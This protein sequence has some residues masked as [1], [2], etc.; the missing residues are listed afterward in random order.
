MKTATDL[1]TTARH[2]YAA[3][4][5]DEFDFM[6]SLENQPEFQHTGPTI[7]E[8]L[9]LLLSEGDEA[10]KP[11]ANVVEDTL[12]GTDFPI[13]RYSFIDGSFAVVRE[14]LSASPPYLEAVGSITRSQ[15]QAIQKYSGLELK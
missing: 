12:V 9:F 8:M 3:A 2:L 13:W 15:A 10:K 4:K 1:L 11:A 14:I 7:R 5:G 6:C